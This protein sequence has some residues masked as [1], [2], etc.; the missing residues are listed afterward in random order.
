MFDIEKEEY[1][2]LEKHGKRFSIYF[3]NEALFGWIE[4]LKL[5]LLSVVKALNRCGRAIRHV[6][7]ERSING[8][9]FSGISRV[10]MRIR[11][12]MMTA[13]WDGFGASRRKL[14]VILCHFEA[15]HRKLAFVA[16]EFSGKLK[17]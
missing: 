7:V 17:H 11:L 6:N 2:N 16:D 9:E 14:F 12:I 5:F 4:V 3:E 1:G 13:S 15:I 10:S 8:F